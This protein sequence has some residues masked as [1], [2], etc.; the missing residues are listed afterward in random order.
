MK[1]SIFTLGL[2][3]AILA[4]SSCVKDNTDTATDLGHKQIT[5]TVT[6]GDETRSSYKPGEGIT[7]DKNESMTV[8]Y[9]A[10][11]DED[12]STY[13][14]AG[15]L[16]ASNDGNNNFTFSHDAI[17]EATAYDYYFMMPDNSS[18]S[19]NDGKVA[20][21]HR[22]GQVQRPSAT[23][24]D[25]S[26]DYIVG[27]PVTIAA[28]NMN[29]A[30]V[31]D[32]KRLVAPLCITFNDS[33]GLLSGQKIHSVNV[34]A[35]AAASQAASLQGLFY[36]NY[37][38]V[39]ADC[40][41]SS[42]DKTAV[43]NGMTAS[44]DEGIEQEGSWESWF[45]VRETT[46][47]AGDMTVTIVGDKNTIKRTFSM[48]EFTTVMDKINRLSI[49]LSSSNCT[50][51]N[52]FTVDFSATTTLPTQ[53]TTS[54]GQ[55]LAF[56][57]E[58]CQ[59]KTNPTNG[60][61]LQINQNGSFTLAAPAEGLKYKAIYLT[62]QNT[63]GTKDYIIAACSGETEISS[64]NFNYYNEAFRGNGGVLKLDIAEEYGANAITIK[65]TDSQSN[66]DCRIIRLTVEYE[67]EAVQPEP[68]PV[69]ESYYTAWQNGEDITIG[70]AAEDEFVVNKTLYPESTLITADMDKTAAYSALQAG[71][72]IFIEKDF[73]II[74]NN[75]EG[76]V[77]DVKEKHLK[78]SK[79]K[80]TIIIGVDPT[81]QPYIEVLG[82][83]YANGPLLA[84]K[85][86][87]FKANGSYG[88]VNANESSCEDDC[89]LYIEDCT[90]TYTQNGI[91]ENN[92]TMARCY[93][94]IYILNSVIHAEI[95]SKNSYGTYKLNVKTNASGYAKDFTRMKAIK[96]INSIFYAE[97]DYQHYL[98]D[99][100]S[101]AADNYDTD[102]S[103]LA[104]EIKNCTLYGLHQSNIMARAY[105]L[106]KSYFG[107]N[108]GYY[109]NTGDKNT[110]VMGD[111]AKTCTNLVMEYN[112]L[113]TKSDVGGNGWKAVNQSNVSTYKDTT[114]IVKA[115]DVDGE[116][117][118][119]ASD[120]SAV[121]GYFPINY[122]IVA[123]GCGA[124]YETKLW[125]AK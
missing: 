104:I 97:S 107:Y 28:E 36:V 39:F 103:N 106:A 100:G 53:V 34:V 58:A 14:F 20:S 1:K 82:Q 72:L 114:S 89:K 9:M 56:T 117:F 98:I 69:V 68:E 22:L 41:I 61:A 80:E 125:L 29:A 63:N 111:F 112:H 90:Y 74:L 30:T 81:S 95:G 50:V 96:Y 94:H 77:A 66:N 76:A 43:S 51:T 119:F 31:I 19:M 110:Y 91:A 67:G 102:T 65:R 84:L 57:T 4:L 54:E 48:G 62:E 40:K 49:N 85:N 55:A 35:S 86:I 10:N 2:M 88:I 79:E 52:S 120:Y 42:W 60:N 26:F 124:S 99:A 78:F 27:K 12:L 8:Y 5:Q 21:H 64:G 71:G 46:I 73:S 32:Y 59:I 6:L 44:Y 92:A 123:A 17:G 118:P 109:E 108:V 33:E 13:V 101:K 75:E 38:D 122:S 121:N 93:S 83:Y 18:N 16:S 24:F 45:M 105:K 37:S 115:K 23:S 87:S 116:Y 15:K 47:P 25:P 70:T 7:I 113:T 3:S 11:D